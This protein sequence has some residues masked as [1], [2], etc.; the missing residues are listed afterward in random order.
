MTYRVGKTQPA[1]RVS[2]DV[3]N[4]K[5]TN[6]YQ[7][8][9]SPLATAVKA[10]IV[11]LGLAHGAGQ[12]AT[13]EVNSSL[14]DGTG[15]TLREALTSVST[16]SLAIGCGISGGVF[17]PGTD[18]EIYIASS[19]AG[20]TISLTNGQLEFISLSSSSVTINGNGVTIDANEQSRVLYAQG[21]DELTLNDMTL[22]NGRATEF[23]TSSQRIG[24]SGG[25]IYL[26]GN[27]ANINDTAIT[28][29][30]AYLGG[31]IRAS[32]TE[33]NINN[34]SVS[35][36]NALAE[37]Y[38]SAGGI[39]I[40][41]YA[42][43][44]YITDGSLSLKNSKVNDNLVSFCC[45]SRGGGIR[46]RSSA[47]YIDTSEISGNQ[48]ISRRGAGGGISKS[49]DTPFDINRS[50][51]S[52]NF[53]DYGGGIYVRGSME[54]NDSSISDNSASLYG[55]GVYSSDL[56]V[57]S[58]TI[59]INNSTISG[60]TVSPDP[61]NSFLGTGGG[62]IRAGSLT[63]NINNS[64][65]SG[66]TTERS[67][68]D[69]DRSGQAIYG[70]RGNIDF[71]TNINLHNSTVV[72]NV[73]SNSVSYDTDAAIWG[74]RS[75]T[76]SN[77]IV[78]NAGG[79]CFTY[80]G[81]ASSDNASIVSGGSCGTGARDI[82]PGVLRLA[83]N[84][85]TTTIGT[86]DD[87][88]CTFTHGLNP[89][90][91]AIDTA[92]NSTFSIDQI[93]TPRPQGVAADVGAVESTIFPPVPAGFTVTAVD[94]VEGVDINV[95]FTITLD[96]AQSVETNY[97]F[98]TI[99]G[100]AIDGQDYNG[101]VGQVSFPAGVTVRERRVRVLEDGVSN[102]PDETFSFVVTDINNPAASVTTQA[103]IVDS[104]NTVSLPTIM[105]QRMLVP[106]ESERAVVEVLLSEAFN[107]QIIVDFTTAEPTDQ[108]NPATSGVDYID[109]DGRIVFPAGVTRRTRTITLIDDDE[110]EG[111]EV[112]NFDLSNPI[113]AS[114][115]V[116]SDSRQVVIVSDDVAVDNNDLPV[117]TVP[118]TFAVEG[119]GFARVEVLLSEASTEE[120]RVDFRTFVPVNQNNPATPGVDYIDRSGT[121]VFP[122]GV[123]RRT[124]TMTVIDDSNAEPNEAFRFEL[125]NPRNAEIADDG[126]SLQRVF[127]INDD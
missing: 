33:L 59:T 115:G 108:P 84:G 35:A 91:P 110:V 109:I 99:D 51:I 9:L 53:A 90:S 69:R 114:I 14:D 74:F 21:F 68:N 32:N 72:N 112:I 93:G 61:A 6:Y 119:D 2:K 50:S 117:L 126:S 26:N 124:R 49:D 111:N 95:L 104:N 44:I 34:S 97:S 107:E 37:N 12:A 106:E 98:N 63:L 94:A 96:Q 102:E 3:A 81:S 36:N 52:N 66:N 92:V 85:C 83:D 65:L 27:T 62:G 103:T 31:G 75:L 15:C 56:N 55:G 8:A 17:G 13:I 25:G 113:N 80:E 101:R 24:R 127:I 54:I 122:P 19:L 121:I 4:A 73:G 43:G 78:A 46:A 57:V 125:T 67:G 105:V 5:P 42:G 118:R 86:L 88:A 76:I 47:V 22:I 100:T 16:N 116:G 82:N 41:A 40:S 39:Y 18:N 123:V 87:P 60:N 38:A 79:N 77:S 71:G 7:P 30:R 89:T 23:T 70:F 48:V 20:N 10:A 11:G 29:N 120:I 64:T 28:N 1:L 58:D 45:A